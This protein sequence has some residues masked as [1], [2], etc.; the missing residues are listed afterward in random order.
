[1]F[2]SSLKF[3]IYQENIIL[4]NNRTNKFKWQQNKYFKVFSRIIALCFINNY[5]ICAVKLHSINHN[6]HIVFIGVTLRKYL[7]TLLLLLILFDLV[8]FNFIMV[9][10]HIHEMNLFLVFLWASGF[11]RNVVGANVFRGQILFRYIITFFRNCYMLSS[12]PYRDWA[13]LSSLSN[14]T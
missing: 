14:K 12:I 5:F 11:P 4:H 13:E 8:L 6:A 7:L 1:M 10:V 9:A 3:Y 2:R